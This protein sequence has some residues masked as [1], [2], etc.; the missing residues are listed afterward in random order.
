MGITTTEMIQFV[1]Q[2]SFAMSQNVNSRAREHFILQKKIALMNLVRRQP[3]GD[4][5]TLRAWAWAGCVH[6]T[7]HN[8]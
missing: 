1:R 6:G 3:L 8:F 5:E 7:R 2:R 4:C